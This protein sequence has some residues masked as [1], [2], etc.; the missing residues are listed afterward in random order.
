MTN[1]TDF[2]EGDEVAPAAPAQDHVEEKAAPEAES[3]YVNLVGEGKKFSD[4]EELA[5]AKIESDNHIS[6]IENENA[7]LRKKLESSSNNYETILSKLEEKE[8][9]NVSIKDNKD[10][11]S[12]S[13]PTEE[14]DLD[15]WFDDK[16]TQRERK[17]IENANMQESKNLMIKA[18][19][20]LETAKKVRDEL[21]A[22]K[23]YMK[24]AINQLIV[25]N[26]QQLIEEIKAFQSPETVGSISSDPIGNIPEGHVDTNA[27]YITWSDANKIRKKNIKQYSSKEFEELMQRSVAYYK[28][29]GVD[30]YTT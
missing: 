19:G 5:K 1:S 6:T 9:N 22:A 27:Q 24:D 29:K 10:A 16:L 12:I 30:F 7:D 25:G 17:A 2:L 18:Y 20:N 23:P 13:E 28:Q 4:A 3:L 21:L 15:Q 11:S 14:V 26:P 8:N